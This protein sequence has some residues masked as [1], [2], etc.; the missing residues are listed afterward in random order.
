[1]NEEEREVRAAVKGLVG[2]AEVEIQWM[3]ERYEGCHATV[4]PGEASRVGGRADRRR[5]SARQTSSVSACAGAERRRE[6]RWAAPAGGGP[7]VWRARRLPGDPELRARGY[8]PP[9]D[10]VGGRIQRAPHEYHPRR[11][12]PPQGGK[13]HP[14]FPGF[15]EV[16]QGPR[17]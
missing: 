13:G 5:P 7:P 2:D 10:R 8:A 3:L 15:T 16:P 4:R 17:L 14:Q 12:S 11:R 6:G 1:M 9:L